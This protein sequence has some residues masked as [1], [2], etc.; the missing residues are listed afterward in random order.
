[1]FGS[2]GKYLEFFELTIP[3]SLDEDWHRCFVFH[4]LALDAIKG[5]FGSLVWLGDTRISAVASSSIDRST[6]DLNR[7]EMSFAMF[8]FDRKIDEIANASGSSRGK[9]D[10]LLAITKAER[11]R[12]PHRQAQPTY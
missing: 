12:L 6:V 8:D 7:G 4:R 11:H 5:G 2:R 9:I 10:G 1:M 3:T